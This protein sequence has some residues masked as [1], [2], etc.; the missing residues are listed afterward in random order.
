MGIVIPAA[1]AVNDGMPGHLVD[2]LSGALG[3]R[4]IGL[5]GARVAVLGYAYL[6]DSDDD[7]NSPSAA[8]V[9]RLEAEGASVVVHDPWVPAFRG[10]TVDDAIAATEGV[11]STALVYHHDEAL[12][13][14][15]TNR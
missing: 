9:A 12:D 8:L 10:R 2:V 14:E 6:E 13:D 11:L 1:R 15:S 4:G 5:S 7:R 3:E